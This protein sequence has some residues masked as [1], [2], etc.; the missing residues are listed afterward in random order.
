MQVNPHSKLFEYHKAQF[1]NFG[2]RSDNFVTILE[3]NNVWIVSFTFIQ[4]LRCNLWD[5]YQFHHRCR[6]VCMDTACED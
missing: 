3:G 4:T 5:T 2:P 1:E 6:K